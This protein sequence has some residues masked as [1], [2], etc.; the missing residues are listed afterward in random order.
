MRGGTQ[1]YIYYVSPEFIVASLDYTI[2]GEQSQ[3]QMYPF[4]TGV[5][6]WWYGARDCSL[7]KQR[8]TP[9]PST[10]CPHGGTGNLEGDAL[11]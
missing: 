10:V 1:Q 2:I 8:G 7:L 9:R 4:G 6:I 3:G 5:Q 11:S